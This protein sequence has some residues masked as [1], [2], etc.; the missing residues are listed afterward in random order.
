MCRST[1]ITRGSPAASTYCRSTFFGPLPALLSDDAVTAV[2]STVAT[3]AS[4]RISEPLAHFGQASNGVLSSKVQPGP[5]EAHKPGLNGGAPAAS[6]ARNTGV[7]ETTRLQPPSIKAAATRM[8]L[9]ARFMDPPPDRAS[10][11]LQA[12]RVI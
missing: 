5:G 10:L 2:G 8:R 1:C 7:C 11:G 12:H 3:R 4:G 6:A 9:C